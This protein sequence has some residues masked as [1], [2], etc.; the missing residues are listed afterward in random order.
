[1]QD[2]KRC[3]V[4]EIREAQHAKIYNY[5]NCRPKLLKTNAAI[6]LIKMYKNRQMTAKY[7]SIKISGNNRQIRTTRITG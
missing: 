5:K 6:W 4:I 1:V 3:R 7:Y 2:N